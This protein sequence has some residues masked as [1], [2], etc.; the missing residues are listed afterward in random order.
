MRTF[1]GKLLRPP[2]S[3]L[4]AFFGFELVHLLVCP[5][6]VL[7]CSLAWPYLFQCSSHS[8]QNRVVST[9]ERRGCPKRDPSWTSQSHLAHEQ[10]PSRR[11]LLN[12]LRCSVMPERGNTLVDSWQIGSSTQKYVTCFWSSASCFFGTWWTIVACCRAGYL[13]KIILVVFRKNGWLALGGR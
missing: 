2:C 3:C 12:S 1:F 8:W 10:I 13:F 6:T 5:H 9:F 7:L 4:S 11:H